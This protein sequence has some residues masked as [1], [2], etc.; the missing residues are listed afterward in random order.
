MDKNDEFLIF[1]EVADYFV[2]KLEHN[3]PKCSLKNVRVFWLFY[4]IGFLVNL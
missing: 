4:N 3:D 2:F 1:K